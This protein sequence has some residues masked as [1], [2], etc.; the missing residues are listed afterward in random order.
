M[1]QWRAYQQR[2]VQRSAVQRR[3]VQQTVDGPSAKGPSARGP[4]HL[5]RRLQ[6][7]FKQNVKS[8]CNKINTKKNQILSSRGKRKAKTK[9]KTKRKINNRKTLKKQEKQ[10]KHNKNKG[11]QGNTRN[12]QVT[13]KENLRKTMK[14]DEKQIKKEKEKE[15]PKRF[16][17]PERVVDPLCEKLQVWGSLPLCAPREENDKNMPP[18]AIPFVARVWQ[19]RS[20]IRPKPLPRYDAP[21]DAPPALSLEGVGE[22][23][24]SWLTVPSHP[25]PPCVFRVWDSQK[26]THSVV[27]SFSFSLCRYRFRRILTT[28]FEFEKSLSAGGTRALFCEIIPSPMRPIT[29]LGHVQEK[30]KK[31]EK[32][33][34]KENVEMSML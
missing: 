9:R 13:Y 14:N 19:T 20:I 16:S 28:H 3:A 7:F 15:A 24:S 30:A 22:H 17:P 6:N 8:F 18:Q 21:G 31:T 5:P 10:G 25:G 2:A 23:A 27:S 32:E 29:W 34:E 1:V 4:G 33:T 11:K 26:C 12:K